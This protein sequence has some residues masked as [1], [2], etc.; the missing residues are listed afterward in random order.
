MIQSLSKFQHT[1]LSAALGMLV[2]FLLYFILI[3]PAIAVRSN[4][5]ERL[6]TLMLQYERMS[7]AAARIPQLQAAIA[8][9]RDAPADNAAFLNGR[10]A[11]LAA[12]ELQKYLESVIEK[13]NGSLRSARVVP[14]DKRGPFPAV[15]LQVNTSGDVQSL[16]RILYD[17]YSGRPLL[18][19]DN[20]LIKARDTPASR[21]A[22]SGSE[23]IELQ[24][25]ATGFSNR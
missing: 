17:M 1:A 16:Q 22:Q 14:A 21:R 10:S 24:F 11:A 6:E 23:G 19:L 7:R 8:G 4:L 18:L 25:V 9:L 20:V 5:A 13:H 2:L 15:A 3:A 12:A